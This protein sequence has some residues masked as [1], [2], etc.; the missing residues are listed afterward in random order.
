MAEQERILGEVIMPPLRP[1]ASGSYL[2]EADYQNPNW[3]EDFYGEPYERLTQIKQKLDPGALF[4]AETAIGSDAWTVAAD[5]R[6]C[7]A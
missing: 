5:G 1:F 7:R 2:N 4:Y 6:M 3:K